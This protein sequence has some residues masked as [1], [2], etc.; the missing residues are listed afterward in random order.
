MKETF[1]K[2]YIEAKERD[3]SMR[4]ICYIYSYKRIESVINKKQIF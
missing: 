2:I 1:D 3:L 4:D